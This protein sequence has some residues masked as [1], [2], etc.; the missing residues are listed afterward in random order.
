MAR[1]IVGLGALALALAAAASTLGQT[2]V[3]HGQLMVRPARGTINL[4]SGSA[5]FA[6][7]GW[8]LKPASNSPSGDID[9]ATQ[10]VLIA[11]GSETSFVLPVGQMHASRNHKRFA[12]QTKTARGITRLVLVHQGDGN[13]RVSFQIVGVD[14]STLLVNDPPVCL[15]MAVIVGDN[16]G[17][18]GISFD[19]PKPFPSKLLT[20]PGF[21]TTEQGWPWT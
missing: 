11:I 15:P 1:K 14:L 4:D 10:P 8:E 13:W 19:R 2:P 17:F 3:Y 6:V 20:I 21:C 9:P 12:Y 7:R 16:D 5:S 18:S